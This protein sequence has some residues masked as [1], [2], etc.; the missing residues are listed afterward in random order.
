MYWVP[1]TNSI[2]QENNKFFFSFL[3]KVHFSD[4][5]FCSLAIA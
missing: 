2:L 3:K 5:R 4:R 1:L